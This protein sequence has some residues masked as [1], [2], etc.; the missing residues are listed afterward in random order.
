VTALDPLLPGGN[1]LPTGSNTSSLVSLPSSITIPAGQLQGQF[2]IKA[3]TSSL[4]GTQ[5]KVTIMA[6]AIQSWT[7]TLTIDF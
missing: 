6:G 7:R 2:A 4:H 5:R 3:L 1:S